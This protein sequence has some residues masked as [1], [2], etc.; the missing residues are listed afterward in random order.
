MKKQRARLLPYDFTFSASTSTSIL[1][2]SLGERF[3]HLQAA[4]FVL[5]THVYYTNPAIFV[6]G[7][8]RAALFLE[9][10]FLQFCHRKEGFF[11]TEILFQQSASWHFAV[12]A[13]C[14]V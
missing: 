11:G 5:G 7:S 13:V 8:F 1:K 2:F 10:E 14:Q 12:V 4:L 9:D 6:G 3:Y